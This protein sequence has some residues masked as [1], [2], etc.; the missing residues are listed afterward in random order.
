MKKKIKLLFSINLNLWIMISLLLLI[1]SE[2]WA[3]HTMYVYGANPVLEC[4]VFFNVF[5]MSLNIFAMN[6]N[7]KKA[8][9]MQEEAEKS[10]LEKPTF[11]KTN[12][13]E[14]G[15]SEQ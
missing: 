13:N 5:V 6:L 2:I 10:R 1:L 15:E 11:D 7:Y 9:R 12:S 8:K 3:L 4:Q 14:S